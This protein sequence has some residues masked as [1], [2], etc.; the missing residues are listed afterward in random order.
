MDAYSPIP[1]EELDEALGLSRTR[2]PMLVLMGGILGGLGGL[3]PRVLDAGRS[4]TR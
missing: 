4:P 2:L 1:I 3:R